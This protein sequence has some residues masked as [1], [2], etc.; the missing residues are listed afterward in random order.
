ML[1]NIEVDEQ[2]IEDIKQLKK[3]GF[4][5]APDDFIYSDSWLPLVKIADI[6]KID[7]L[8]TSKEEVRNRLSILQKYPTKLLAEKVK[9]HQILTLCQS[10]KFD[11]LQGCF[12]IKPQLI[13]G[14][15]LESNHNEYINGTRWGTGKKI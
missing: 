9:N 11:Y 6:I 15:K 1:E 10:Q 13:K 2:V 4:T 12:L 3:K 14:T 7:V 8:S 5:I